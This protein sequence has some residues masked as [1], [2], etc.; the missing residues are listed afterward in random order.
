M[1]LNDGVRM[2]ITVQNAE[3]AYRVAETLVVN[4]LRK[5]TVLKLEPKLSQVHL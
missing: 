4:L 2:A 3:T 5:R 1:K